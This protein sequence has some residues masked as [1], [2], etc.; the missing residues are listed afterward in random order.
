MKP[1]PSL[2]TFLNPVKIMISDPLPLNVIS[3]F[4]NYVIRY[5]LPITGAPDAKHHRSL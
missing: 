4:L 2:I 5:T 1:L 3:A